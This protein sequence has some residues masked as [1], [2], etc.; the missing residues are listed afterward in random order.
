MPA[1]TAKKESGLRITRFKNITQ[2]QRVTLT[3]LFY[4]QGLKKL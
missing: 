4:L 2:I 3:R 1:S